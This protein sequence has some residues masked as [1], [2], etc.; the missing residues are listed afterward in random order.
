MPSFCIPY[1]EFNGIIQKNL[2]KQKTVHSLQ[3]T[4]E[5]PRDSVTDKESSKDVAKN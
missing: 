4:L 1:Q 2:V 5:H 3:T